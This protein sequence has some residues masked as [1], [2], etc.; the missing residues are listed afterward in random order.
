[1]RISQSLFI[2]TCSP[3]EVDLVA[4]TKI[5]KP[6]LETKLSKVFLPRQSDNLIHIIHY[7]ILRSS[8]LWC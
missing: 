3:M 6:L 2:I 1:M 7:D 5:Q 4:Q 8:M